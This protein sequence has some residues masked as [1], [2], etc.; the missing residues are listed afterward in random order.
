MKSLHP[1]LSIPVLTVVWGLLFALAAHAAEPVSSQSQVTPLTLRQAE[2]W[3]LTNNRELRAAK[4]NIEAAQADTVIAGQRPNPVLSFG[5]SS[6]NLNRSQGNVNQNGA[7]GLLD[8]TYNSSLQL[9]Q[10]VERGGKREL[11]SAVAENALKASDYDWKD[12]LRVQW[13][14][15]LNAYYDLKLAQDAQQI[16]TENQALYQRLLQAAELRLKA[17]DVSSAEV[18]RIRVDALR[19]GNDVRQAS[20]NLQKA[21]ATLAYLL[22]KDEEAGRLQATDPWLTPGPA[23]MAQ[24]QNQ[25]RALSQRPDVLASDARITQAEAAKKLANALQTR[26]VTVGLGYQHFPGQAPGAGEN[27]VGASISIPLY[28]NYQYQGEAA[29]AEVDLAAAEEA[30][31]Q[32]LAI[33]TLEVQR[34]TADLQAAVDKQKRFDQQI[35]QEAQKAADAAE[36]AYQHGA[37]A[38]SDLL[39]ARRVY[40]ALQ[41][42]AVSVKADYAKSLAAWQ[43]ATCQSETIESNNSNE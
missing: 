11:R 37:M 24:L 34:A 20:A 41:L 14:A 9:S 25:L 38:V 5:F 6:I 36:F 26:D 31:A 32:T 28:T 43:T 18:A 8:K 12:T 7:N 33:A 16:Q 21:Q 30:K 2:Q 13:L 40:R 17:G 22:G 15:M 3:F 10:L 27:T 19:A 42:E 39:D 35:L 1:L 29:R 4:R 23:Q